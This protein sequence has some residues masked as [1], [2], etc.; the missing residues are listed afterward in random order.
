MRYFGKVQL[1]KPGR[2]VEIGEI[3]KDL[4]N[5]TGLY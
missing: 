5:R 3:V 1:V 4:H 2:T